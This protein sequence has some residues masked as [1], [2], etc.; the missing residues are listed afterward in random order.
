MAGVI[1][2]G[3]FAKDLFPLVGQWYGNAYPEYKPE[4]SQIF[5]MGTSKGKYVEEVGFVGTGLAA[6]K[7]EGAGIAYDSM[8]QGY[9]TRYTNVT[10]GLG[11][12]ITREAYE[13]AQWDTGAK[14]KAAQLKWSQ[15]QTKEY[16]HA[17]ILNRAFSG[18]YVYAD[19]VELC[20]TN[21]PNK[22]GGT[23][24]NELATAADLSVA[25][26]EQGCIDVG[27]FT[28]DRGGKIGI[29]T[30]KLVIPWALEFEAERILKS[31]LE[32]GT[33]YNDINAVRSLG[34]FPG[35][36][37]INHFLTD[38]DAWFILTN[39]PNGLKSFQRRAPEFA[40]ENDF[41]NENARF[42]YTERYSCGATDPRGIYGSPGA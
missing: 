29:L 30:Q 11:F 25:S 21:H 27:G 36:V 38:T 37:I 6:V 33:A 7:A 20:A 1:T 18:S 10:Y 28:N 40:T 13:D 34:K 8:E 32:S 15:R 4:F 17:M 39:C 23:W 16:V 26:L 24:A 9:I 41:D 22:S 35:G 2:T 42:K 3:S 31:T 5:E 19:G 12:I 14:Q